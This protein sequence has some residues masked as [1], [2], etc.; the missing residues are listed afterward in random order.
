MLS[1]LVTKTTS[2]VSRSLLQSFLFVCFRNSRA[3]IKFKSS[4]G[5]KCLD[6]WKQSYLD[7]RKKIELSGRDTRWEFDR[8]KLFERSDYL[9]Q[10][11]SD[12]YDVA[13]VSQTY[14]S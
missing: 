1:H 4:E 9:S 3:A 5:K 13:Q 2:L 12:I 6:T 14:A 7:V 8:K 11:C 10:V